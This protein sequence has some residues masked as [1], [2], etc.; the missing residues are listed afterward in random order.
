MMKKPLFSGEV[1]RLAGVNSETL[2]YYEQHGFLEKP[3]RAES[4]YR[5]YSPESV[6]RIR[7]IKRAQALGF[8]LREIKDLLALSVGRNLK[9]CADVRKR[10]E[11][12]LVS[13]KEKIR[14]L[15][16]MKRSL[17]KLIATCNARKAT[18][19]CPLLDSLNEGEI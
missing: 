18:S 14:E 17:E 12:K 6:Q 13:A 7:F 19:A 8:S 11:A 9:R 1:A 3:P 10:A 5:L 4:G 15:Q 2:R 16:S